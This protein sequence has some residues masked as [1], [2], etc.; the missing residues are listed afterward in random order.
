[1]DTRTM[2]IGL[3]QTIARMGLPVLILAVTVALAT[4]VV[5]LAAVELLQPSAEPILSAPIRWCR[6]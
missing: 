3:S 2:L 1:M 6:H 4:F 5:A